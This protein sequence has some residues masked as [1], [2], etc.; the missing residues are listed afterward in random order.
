MALC[1]RI[2][3]AQTLKLTNENIA[4]TFGW[5]G[6]SSLADRK[7]NDVVNLDD[8]QFSITL[9]RIRF[10]SAEL[11]PKIAQN[12]SD[13]ITY[14]YESQGYTV[15]VVYRLLPEWTFVSKELQVAKAPHNSYLVHSV[16]PLHVSIGQP[17]LSVFTPGTYLPQFGDDKQVPNRLPTKQFGEFLRFRQSQGLMLVVQNP[18]LEVSDEGQKVSISYQPEMMWNAAWGVFKSD[19]SCIGRYRL[20]D[21]RIPRTMVPEWRVPPSSVVDDG[22]D[23]NE[24]RA[25]TDCV[26]AFLVSPSPKP[27]SIEVGWTLNDYQIDVSKP[28]GQAE[29]KRIID[30]TADLGIHTLLYAPA[31]YDLAKIADDADDWNWEHVLWLGLGQKIREGKWNIENS[32]IPQSITDMLN[33]AKSKHVGLLAYVYPSLPFSQDS[34]WLRKDSNKPE[35]NAYAALSSREFQDFLIHS[36]LVF[37]RRTGI[38][39]YSFDY[40]FLNV[41]GTSSYSQWWGWRRVMESLRKGEPSI[42]IDGRQ[43]YQTYG[44]WSWLGGSYPHP[45]GNDEQPESFQPYPDL[46]FDRVSANRERFVD[47]WYRNYQFAPE[48]LVPGYI[49]HQTERSMNMHS[50]GSS[51]G[52]RTTV[53]MMYTGYRQRDWDYLGYRYSLISSIATGGWNSVVD[54]IPAR[55]QEEFGN[56]SS[57]DKAWIRHWLGWADANAEFLLNTRTILG[58]PA[59]GKVDGTSALVRDHGYLFLFNPNYKVVG[60]DFQLDARI[61]L[62]SG[63]NFTLRELYPS[64]GT[65]LGKP[66]AGVWN[67]GDHVHLD[68]Q[69][70]SATVLEVTPM[71]MP[72]S[73]P[74]VFNAV[75]ADV[76]AHVSGS[77]L[78]VDHVSGEPGSEN[79]IGVLLPNNEPVKNVVVNGTGVQFQQTG[80][81]ITA[82]VKFAGRSF[83]HSQQVQLVQGENKL[84]GTFSVPN[85]ILS[86][87][88]ER[89][90][91]WPIPWTSEDYETTWLAPERLLLFVQIAEGKDTEEPTIKMD[92]HPLHLKNAYSSVRRHSPS[93][94]GFYA[95]VSDIEPDVEHTMEVELPNLRLGQF[96][97]VFFDNVEPEYTEKLAP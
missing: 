67:Y 24:I 7:S 57:S 62:A 16:E 97:G 58:Q 40:T 12:S 31:N 64:G 20:S 11:R 50:E 28:E 75:G 83:T 73:K 46:H 77:E 2:C 33:Y 85:R 21:H 10:E 1:L 89:K 36:L 17:I 37:K 86:Q 3:G 61:G 80:H 26:N 22:A 72:A 8:D 74:V 93:F 18:F 47:Y 32:N 53:K 29:Y 30:M 65:P 45:T 42:I 76:Y 14:S 79:E 71:S 43:T 96:Q 15:N 95:D 92:G 54:M 66:S 13:T 68:L 59:I 5:K 27:I 23:Y 94:V 84:S 56:F 82:K 90:K 81:Y 39:G 25:F 4:A 78:I 35:K 9:D 49:T 88:S 70:T 41:P 91:H 38:A 19:I 48:R 69:G 34:H 51:D 52:G 60:A 44:P 55:D 6:L 63:T 87:L